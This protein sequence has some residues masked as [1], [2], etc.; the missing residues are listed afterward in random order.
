MA[1]KLSTIDELIQKAVESN[2]IP[3]IYFNVF[4]NGLGNSD[5]VIVLQSNGKPVAVLNTSFTIAKTLVQ[6][7]NDVI[8]IIEKNSGNTIMT[9]MDID[10]ALTKIGK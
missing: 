1:D 5:I 3:K 10:K 7:L 9:T 4:G 2:E 8:G 6:K